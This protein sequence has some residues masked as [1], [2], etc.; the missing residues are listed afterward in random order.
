MSSTDGRVL[1]QQVSVTLVF[2]T[3]PIKELGPI[4]SASFNYEA[5]IIEQGYLGERGNRY[6][7]IYKGIR[8]KLD[9]HLDNP[10]W[11]DFVDQVVQR[12]QRLQTFVINLNG[13]F[14]F[15][16][17]VNRRLLIPDISLGMI[18]IEVGSRTEYVKSGL[19]FAAT[20]GRWARSA[21]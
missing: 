17:G 8:G 9:L 11:P 4:L 7:E 6:D 5:E 2:P 20:F 14:R 3:R 15:S 16:S 19:D 21:A 18:P 13:V 12:Q 1:G 10:N